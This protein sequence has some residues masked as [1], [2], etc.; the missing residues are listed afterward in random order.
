MFRQK[1]FL[2]LMNKSCRDYRTSKC[3]RSIQLKVTQVSSN[4]SLQMKEI[5]R[6]LSNLS[7]INLTI[8]EFLTF[9]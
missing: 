4:A 5:P 7:H 2:K 6:F 8:C 1:V 3:V 9:K